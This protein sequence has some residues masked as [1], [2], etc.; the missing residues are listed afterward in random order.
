MLWRI[1]FSASMIGLL[2]LS[3]MAD[4][5]FNSPH[6]RAVGK[7]TRAATRRPTTGSQTP[8]HEQDVD[9]STAVYRNLI[10]D[11]KRAQASLQKSKGY[12]ARFVR[13]VRKED[14]LRDPEEMSLKIRHKPF[15]VYLQWNDTGKE[16]LFV[17]GRNDNHLLVKLNEGLLSFAGT[18]KLAPR[19]DKAMQDSRYPITDIGL[20]N[21]VNRVLKEHEDAAPAIVSYEQEDRSVG[22]VACVC[23]TIRIPSRD[24]HPEYSKTVLHI[25][26]DSGLP[27]CIECYG[28]DKNRPGGLLERYEYHSVTQKPELTDADFDPKEYGLN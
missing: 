20:L 17:E 23:Y 10:T 18:L 27:L 11:L 2:L 24:V 8:S 4:G 12:R 5:R 28:W 22:D 13:Q 7:E 16:V 25:C 3:F 14:G 26:A 1:L 15:S 9:R 6:H 21:L 19:S